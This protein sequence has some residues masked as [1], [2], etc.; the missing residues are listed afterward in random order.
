MEQT[1]NIVLGPRFQVRLE[2]LREWHAIEVRCFACKH[3]ALLY[4]THLKRRW[5]IHTRLVDLERKLV[6][7]SCGNRTANTWRIVQIDRNA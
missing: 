7:R 6:C 3:V 4:P 1:R 2:D 5:S